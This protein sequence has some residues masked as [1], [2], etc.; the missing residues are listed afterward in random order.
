MTALKR[1]NILDQAAHYDEFPAISNA[2]Y[3]SF[4]SF[5]GGRLSYSCNLWL[6]ELGNSIANN[7]AKATINKW[8]EYG[9]LLGWTPDSSIKVLEI[10]F[11]F[12]TLSKWIK[13]EYGFNV[14]SLNV[15]ELNYNLATED[16]EGVN[17]IHKS[18]EE[19]PYKNEFD[20]VISEGVLV[21]QRDKKGFFEYAQRALKPSGKALI[22]EMHFTTGSNIN[23]IVCKGLNATYR[24]SGSYVPTKENED[25]L[26]DIGFWKQTVLW[27]IENYVLT[28]TEWLDKMKQ[29]KVQMKAINNDAWVHRMLNFEM[30]LLCFRRNTFEMATF[31]CE[32]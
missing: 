22:R 15:S 29:N 25:I 12:G 21:H 4:F 23:A 7:N 13:G 17:F 9:N 27:D 30:F 28:Q 2:D 31:L 19:S 1:N 14:T 3:H 26:K 11:G 16:S 10:G 24:H 32:K 20:F 6:D 18:W 5:L 8:K